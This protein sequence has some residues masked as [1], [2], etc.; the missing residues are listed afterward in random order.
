[1]E[2]NYKHKLEGVLSKTKN[3]KKLLKAK[4]HGNESRPPKIVSYI[5]TAIVPT[6]DERGKPDEIRIGFS[7]IMKA[8]NDMLAKIFSR[9]KEIQAANKIR[10]LQINPF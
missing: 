8:G 5:G 9:H 3:Q 2:E 10:N 1:M 6:V 7:G 4:G